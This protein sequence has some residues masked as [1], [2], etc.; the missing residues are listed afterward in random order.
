VLAIRVSGM[1]PTKSYIGQG[2]AAVTSGLDGIK[3][4]FTTFFALQLGIVIPLTK[5]RRE[6]NKHKRGVSIN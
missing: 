1:L 4:L 6:G 2:G 3:S 5:N